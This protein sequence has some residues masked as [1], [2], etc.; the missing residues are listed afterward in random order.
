MCVSCAC[1]LFL[2]SVLAVACCW[3]GV[4]RWFVF[5]RVVMC[6]G[7]TRRVLATLV[8]A[9]VVRGKSGVRGISAKRP[10]TIGLGL[11]RVERPPHHG[12]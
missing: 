2:V 3:R 1:L 11:I 10:H 6:L 5:C 8:L 9:K 12:P 4:C 7:S